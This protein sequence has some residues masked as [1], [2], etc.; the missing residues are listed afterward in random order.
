MYSENLIQRTGGVKGRTCFYHLRKCGFDIILSFVIDPMH[1]I[2][3]GVIKA[4]ALFLFSA[5]YSAF[6]Y[7]LADKMAEIDAMIVAFSNI[8]PHEFSR[9]RKLSKNIV[10]YKGIIIAIKLLSLC[11]ES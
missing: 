4:L 5:K 9:F 3:L 11:S 10:H 8:V 1:N 2:F 6:E 7:S